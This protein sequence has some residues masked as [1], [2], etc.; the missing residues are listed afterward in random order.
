VLVLSY[1]LLH[2]DHLSRVW[3]SSCLVRR[4]RILTNCESQFVGWA[5]YLGHSQL[6]SLVGCLH[7]GDKGRSVQGLLL[8]A[9]ALGLLLVARALGEA[10]RQRLLAIALVPGLL[11][12]RPTLSC[13]G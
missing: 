8:V 5:A 10:L 12:K 3:S 9:R 1:P 6:E 7:M 13:L 11:L 2:P 4:D